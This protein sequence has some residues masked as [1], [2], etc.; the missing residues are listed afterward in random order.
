MSDDSEVTATIEAAGDVAAVG[1]ACRGA[2]VAMGFPHF[3]YAFR[4]PMPLTQPCQFILS[5]YPAEWRER[6]DRER[7]LSIDPVLPRALT[8]V[9][10]FAWDE[11]DRSEP[12]VD[13]LFRE[14]AAHGLCHGLSVPVH[15]AH[16]EGGL[17]SLAGPEPL[18]PTG[19]GR[20]QLFQRAQWFTAVVHARMRRLV[21]EEQFRGTSE[22]LTTRERECLQMAAQGLSA[23]V[24]GRDMN[25]AE[26]TVVFHLN[27]A[28]E[29]LGARR[30]QHAV[31]IAVALGEIDPQCYPNRFSESKT[32]IDLSD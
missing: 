6:Y 15:G 2:A 17:M 29:K 14:A 11:L 16:G 13:Q 4:M 18:P 27:R 22:S 28:E 21:F 5:G 9:L 12:R 32:L 20:L 19:P 1:A 7:Y 8:S 23:Q 10:P 3:L 26:R 31:A 24:I 25:I 30:R